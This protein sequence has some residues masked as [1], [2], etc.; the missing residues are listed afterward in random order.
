MVN[1]IIHFN[2]DI[3]LTK[4]PQLTKELVD[5][6]CIVEEYEWDEAAVQL[7]GFKFSWN[8]YHVKEDGETLETIHG[9]TTHITDKY[10]RA[11]MYKNSKKVTKQ[12][13]DAYLTMERHINLL[14][15]MHNMNLINF[16]LYRKIIKA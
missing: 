2:T 4:A 9:G 14:K 15:D 3:S 6:I 16:K 12:Y 11:V 8:I 10:I 7:E 5:I 13:F 1:N